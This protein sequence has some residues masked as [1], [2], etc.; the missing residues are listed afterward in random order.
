MSSQ[1]LHAQEN[2][3][4]LA[5][6]V[7]NHIQLSPYVWASDMKGT[8]SPFR[9]APDIKTHK[10][11]SDIVK[12]LQIGGFINMWARHQDY[13]FSG[14]LIYIKLKDAKTTG[15]LPALPSPLPSISS[16][17]GQVDTS[18]LIFTLQ[19]GTRVIKEENLTLDLLAGARFWHIS[20]KVTLSA[21]HHSTSYK[22]KFYWLDPLIGTRIFYRLN[23]KTSIQT[24]ADIGGFTIGSKFTWSLLSTFNYQLNKHISTSIGYKVLSTNYSRSG[25]RYDVRMKGPVIGGTYRF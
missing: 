9:Y 18:Q 4:N 16:L 25:Y 7:N 1:V 5:A 11:F 10:S 13:V 14:D 6:S 23:D 8:I 17:R 24:Q 3:V 2:N 22:E 21:N 12:D 19:G 20:N 15:P